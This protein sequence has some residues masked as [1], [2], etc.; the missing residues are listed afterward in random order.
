[1]S[2]TA[3]GQPPM[4]SG[5]FAT[6]PWKRAV[7]AILLR[8]PS[9]ASCQNISA[10]RGFAWGTNTSVVRDERP[11]DLRRNEV[12]KLRSLSIENQPKVTTAKDRTVDVE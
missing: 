1:M 2:N 4:M 12:A 5:S 6:K 9:A 7:S 10:D 11:E 3:R 8:S